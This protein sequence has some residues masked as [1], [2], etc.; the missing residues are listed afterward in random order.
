[1]IEWDTMFVLALSVV[2][3]CRSRVRS[4]GCLF[5]GCAPDSSTTAFR[6]W[7]STNVKSHCIKLYFDIRIRNSDACVLPRKRLAG[8]TPRWKPTSGRVDY[9]GNSGRK[10]FVSMKIKSTQEEIVHASIPTSYKFCS[11]LSRQVQV[12]FCLLSL[13]KREPE[14]FV[15]CPP[16]SQRLRYVIE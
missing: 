2:S 12:L 9:A 10:S 6:R 11:S 8:L 7:T 16:R 14:N 13:T 5:N 4:S 15:S 1:L 3:Q